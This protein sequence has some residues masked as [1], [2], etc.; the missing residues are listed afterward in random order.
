MSYN[1]LGI[2]TSHNGSAC[3]LIDGKVEFFLEEDRI[4]KRKHDEFPLRIIEYIS[5][6]YKINEISVSGLYTHP[7]N[8]DESILSFYL[9]KYF[10]NTKI[11]Y[12]LHK[13]HFCHSFISFSN[14]LFQEALSIVIDGSGSESISSSNNIKFESESIY[15]FSYN[16]PLQTIYKSYRTNDKKIDTSNPIMAALEDKKYKDT[17]F[18]LL[19]CA[20]P[21]EFN[22]YRNEPQ[23]ESTDLLGL[24]KTYEVL[25]HELGFGKL[26][27]GKT[28]G[29][30]SYGKPNTQIPQLYVN[31]KGN[32]K[33]FNLIFNTSSGEL[34]S[35]YKY[36]L[37]SKELRQDLA[38]KVQ[39]ES[40]QAVGDLIEKYV[41]ETGIKKVC[42]SGGYFLNCVA[43]YYL[44]KRFPNIEF[45][46]EPISS[47]AGTAIGAAKLTWYQKTQDKTI[48]SQKTLYY[49]PKYSKEQL[50]KGIKKYVDN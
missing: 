48:N 26:Q 43:N 7:F 17:I 46:F 12:Y 35:K 16:S 18:H 27:A 28:M 45:Y 50:L 34:K 33:V 42:C 4:T 13:H 9:S 31:T 25:S 39:Q 14:S 1:I 8:L 23:I 47:D 29:L 10:P 37:N 11:N 41:S 36:L 44:I 22:W 19:G 40:Q 3:L 30:S 32:P 38:C 6:N 20:V 2:N 21:Q 24:C 15:K 5:N 49:G